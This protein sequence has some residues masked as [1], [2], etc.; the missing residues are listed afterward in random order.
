MYDGKKGTQFLMRIG[1]LP[2]YVQ[3]LPA[4]E[5]T[6]LKVHHDTGGGPLEPPLPLPE[7]IRFL[8]GEPPP[9]RPPTQN[10]PH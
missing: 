8:D 10:W 1:V 4:I 9:D 6:A 2:G 5:T 3:P 7:L